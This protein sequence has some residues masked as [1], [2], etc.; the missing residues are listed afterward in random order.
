MFY[1]IQESRYRLSSIEE[2]TTEPNIYRDGK[3]IVAPVENAVFP[4]RCVKTNETVA[5]A[6]YSI[7]FEVV[8]RNRGEKVP[9]SKIELAARV[10]AN[11]RK[12]LMNI[13]L[14]DEKKKRSKFLKTLGLVL[15]TAGPI[16]AFILAVIASPSDQS[17]GGG[18]FG[19][20][21]FVMMGIGFAIMIAGLILFALSSGSV[22]QVD[23][24][25]EHRIKLTGACSEFLNELPR[26]GSDNSF[27]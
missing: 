7:A 26:R 4:N 6:D 21:S 17:G 1:F 16:L 22:L 25:F 18:E 23:D 2:M 27:E 12:I 14:C 8:V 10:M 5:S 24:C 15:V 3:L 11:R 20:M 19:V 13:G 9:E